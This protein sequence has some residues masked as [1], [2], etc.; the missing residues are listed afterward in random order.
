MARTCNT[1]SFFDNTAASPISA[2]PFTMACWVR[3]TSATAAQ[4]AMALQDKDTGNN[5]HQLAIR[6]DVG[7]DLVECISRN[8]TQV[9]AQTSSGYTANVWHHI[10]GVWSASNARAAFIDGGS[11]G[12]NT[13]N[14]TFASQDSVSVGHAGDSTPGNNIIGQVAEAGIWNVALT[15]NEIAMLAAGVSP[16]HVRPSG[17]VR[18]WPLLAYAGDAP[19]YSGHG[20]TLTAAG[21]PAEADHAPVRSLFGLPAGWAGNAVAGA[22]TTVDCAGTARANP[23]VVGYGWFKQALDAFV[24]VLI[25]RYP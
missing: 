6:G 10:A 8:T 17:L 2:Y 12:T 15:D 21:T 19:D 23:R 18:Y 7:G 9:Q 16:L 24:T 3:S 5:Y 1:T 11:K 25:K 20:G 14:V 4:I 22:A 13:S